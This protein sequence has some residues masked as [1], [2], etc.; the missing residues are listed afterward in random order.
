MPMSESMDTAGRIRHAWSMVESASGSGSALRSMPL[1]G[2]SRMVS[3]II[4]PA[5]H[6]GIFI[7]L[8]H[9]EAVD[10]PLG[11]KPNATGAL[12]ADIAQYSDQHGAVVNA[13]SVWCLDPS[14]DGAFISFVINFL[15]R[16]SGADLGI[17]LDDCHMEFRRL[18]GELPSEVSN[19][20]TGLLG[21]LLMLR[22]LTAIDPDAFRFWAGPRGERHDFRN[23]NSAVEVKTGLRSESKSDKVTISDWDQLEAPEGG[24]LYL[25]VIRLERVD[26]GEI[27]LGRLLHDIRERLG[28]SALESFE[29]AVVAYVKQDTQLRQAYSIQ[30]RQTY[31]V[32]EGFP[33]LVRRMLPVDCIA[34]I[35]GVSYDLDLSQASAFLY[36]GDATSTLIDGANGR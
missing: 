13:L 23:G 9:G 36:S 7:P 11:M 34:G 30:L 15:D 1:D 17:L 27:T 33:R 20:L 21:E 3:A 12:K 31:H 10:I 29:K 26:G 16:I 8:G 35:S 24:S 6:K 28:G 2:E 5:G 14:C 22:D 18:I 25:H 32:R 4:T 19:R